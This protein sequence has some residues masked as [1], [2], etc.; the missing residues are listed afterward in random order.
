MNLDQVL[1]KRKSCRKFDPNCIMPV[2]HLWILGEAAKHAPYASGGPRR[3]FRVTAGHHKTQEA[4]FGQKYAGEA[5]AVFVFCGKEPEAVLR[6]GHAKYIFD[7][8]AACMCMDLKAVELGYGTC[9]I[10]HFDPDKIR[11]A[12]GILDVWIPTIIL[13][14]GAK[15]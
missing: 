1:F 9:W 7:C 6:S 8:A 13:L 5:S 10:G 14:V 3:V 11:E 12:V 15:A 4:C 2:E